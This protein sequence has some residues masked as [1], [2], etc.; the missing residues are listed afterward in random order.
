MSDLEFTTA[1]GGNMWYKYVDFT[2]ED[3]YFTAVDSGNDGQLDYYLTK[4][5][6]DDGMLRNYNDIDIQ[7]SRPADSS[8]VEYF[9]TTSALGET[10]SNID[11]GTEDSNSNMW[12][13]FA[14]SNLNDVGDSNVEAYYYTADQEGA[15]YHTQVDPSFVSADDVVKTDE[16]PVDEGGEVVFAGFSKPIE[17]LSEVRDKERERKIIRDLTKVRIANIKDAYPADAPDSFVVGFLVTYKEHRK[18][19]DVR[20][21]YEEIPGNVGTLVDVNFDEYLAIDSAW[22]LVQDKVYSWLE[23]KQKNSQKLKGKIWQV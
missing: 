8:N 7:V 1:D 9:T 5:A 16:P 12:Y 2:G 22:N 13:S 15:Y 4:V 6:P 20:I 23:T 3:A 19:V 18:Y 11:Y 14:T 10:S 17:D 21:R